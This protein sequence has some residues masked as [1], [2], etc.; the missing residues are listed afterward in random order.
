M[1][2]INWNHR[3]DPSFQKDLMQEIWSEEVRWSPRRFV[4]LV[5]PWGVEGTPLF[6]HKG[7]R[8]WQTEEMEA[9]EDHIRANLR[10]GTTKTY[11]S[12]TVSGRGVGKS[13]LVG[14]LSV[15]YPSCVVGGTQVITS[16]TE[17]QLRSK[18]FPEILKW[19]TMSLTRDWFTP[20]V[21][22]LS[23]AP[24][25]RRMVESQ[26]KKDCEYY[27]VEGQPWS[28]ARPDAFAG[29][30]SHEGMFLIKDEASGII[31]KIFEISNGFFTEPIPVKLWICFGNG[32]RNTGPFFDIFNKNRGSWKNRHLDSRSVEGT[33][34]DEIAEWVDQ[35]GED[36]DFVRVEIKGEFAALGSDGFISR[37]VADGA[38]K[39]EVLED[40]NAPLIMGVDVA[41][42]GDN[43]TVVAFRQ[44]RSA[45][46]LPWERIKGAD[47]VRIAHKIAF[48]INEHEPDAV[49]IDSDGLGVGVVDLLRDMKYKV[50]E[51]HGSSA[52]SRREYGNKRA[53][54]WADM[55]EWLK[56]GQIPDSS[57]L[58][59]DLVNVRLTYM[60]KTDLMIMESKK[61]MKKRRV[62][63]PD[64]ADALSL[65][66][67]VPVARKGISRRKKSSV[68]RGTDYDVFS[69]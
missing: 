29:T 14:F 64:D 63:S 50:H 67:A 2:G 3:N 5:F 31:D 27:Y 32:R 24:W 33:D 19:H 28:D 37:D 16:N 69:L 53:C 52:S 21:L 11:R 18:T 61:D 20:S 55:E 13:A 58:V 10:D 48:L 44:G 22:K 41:R 46:V 62:P 34:K 35:H 4:E 51:V 17:Q 60:G 43:E 68:P 8:S 47:L 45:V 7:P 25:F 54:M 26:L 15:W 49:C 23:P 36:S 1:S 65:T 39:R 12:G 66:F 57:K 56:T 9:V 6:N 59:D 42:K 38:R 40:V 30:H